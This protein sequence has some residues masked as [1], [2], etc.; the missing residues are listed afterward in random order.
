MRRELTSEEKGSG[1]Q[2][3]RL[4]SPFAEEGLSGLGGSFCGGFA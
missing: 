1:A 4:F 2:R 3:K